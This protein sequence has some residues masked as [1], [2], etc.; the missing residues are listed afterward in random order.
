MLEI[1][2]PV[3]QTVHTGGDAPIVLVCEH[4][5]N[6]IPDCLDDLGIDSEVRSSHAAWDIG[7]RDVAKALSAKLDAPLVACTVSRL[8]YDCNR[9]LSA[10]DCIPSVSEKYAIPG[11]QG[12]S[13][14]ERLQR[15]EQ[16]HDPFHEVVS[17]T[18]ASQQQNADRSITL[19][20]VHSFTPVYN[21]EQRTVEVGFLHSACDRVARAALEREQAKSTL[22]CALNEPYDAS[23]GVTYTLRKHGDA[24]GLAS[25]MVEI[26]NDL[27]DTHDK[28]EDVACHLADTLSFAIDASAEVS[29][30]S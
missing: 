10:P 14:E 5:S 7:A 18:I 2:H 28:A 26:K 9:P 11:N 12:L 22:R 3:A 17:R 16:I 30:S 6:T 13:A 19:V 4:A 8:A 15:C 23:H 24:Y 29:Q 25:I 1:P 20:T 21:G 27:V